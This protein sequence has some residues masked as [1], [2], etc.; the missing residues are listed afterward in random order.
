MTEQE[1]DIASAETLDSYRVASA[2][3][4]QVKFTLVGTYGTTVVSERADLEQQHVQLVGEKG[5]CGREKSNS[6]KQQDKG[7]TVWTAEKEAKMTAFAKQIQAVGVTDANPEVR[8]LREKY[9]MLSE[10]MHELSTNFLTNL[11]PVIH[12]TTDMRQVA[13][14]KDPKLVSLKPVVP[15]SGS[16][17]AE[18]LVAAVVDAKT[19]EERAKLRHLMKSLKR[20]DPVAAVSK[21]VVDY[22]LQRKK[23]IWFST[24]ES[25]QAEVERLHDMFNSF[26]AFVAGHPKYLDVE[27]TGTALDLARTVE[28]RADFDEFLASKLPAGTTFADYIAQC[29]IRPLALPLWRESKQAVAWDACKYY[30]RLGLTSEAMP[31]ATFATH[32]PTTMKM[33]VGVNKERDYVNRNLVVVNA[34]RV[35][36]GLSPFEPLEQL[37]I[38]AFLA[39][40][41]TQVQ[42]FYSGGHKFCDLAAFEEAKLDGWR[43][44]LNGT[45]QTMSQGD[46]EAF[47]DK[48]VAMALKDPLSMCSLDGQIAQGTATLRAITKCQSD[49]ERA[50]LIAELAEEGEMLRN[51]DFTNILPVFNEA[52]C[53]ECDYRPHCDR[54]WKDQRRRGLD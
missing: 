14:M 17:T 12:A 28:G 2:E 37:S 43:F 26:E 53:D 21:A 40:Q 10:V 46:M 47:V 48:L 51:K 49:E 1:R 5:R 50:D 11:F 41:E 3:R 18:G 34:D 25:D 13:L 9:E 8:A 38:E 45:Y 22:Q 16:F 39:D 44:I 42:Y 35:H 54:I 52:L 29:H 7:V 33:W 32:K 23:D 19:K 6:K 15:F 31:L 20:W 36:K 4:E 24:N 30:V 27:V